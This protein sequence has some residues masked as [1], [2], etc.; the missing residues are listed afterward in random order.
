MHMN[1]GSQ[2]QLEP[3]RCTV[4]SGVPPG[5]PAGAGA[6]ATTAPTAAAPLSLASA[7][8]PKKGDGAGVEWR[9][10]GVGLWLVHSTPLLS[11]RWLAALCP[12]PCQRLPLHPITN[13][14]RAVAVRCEAAVHGCAALG[15]AALCGISHPVQ[16]ALQRCGMKGDG[17]CNWGGSTAAPTAQTAAASSDAH[18]GLRPPKVRPGLPHAYI[19]C[20]LQHFIAVYRPCFLSRCR[21]PRLPA[22]PTGSAG[23][24]PHLGCGANPCT[25]RDTAW[26]VCLQLSHPLSRV[27][28]GKPKP[29]AAAGCLG[30]SVCPTCSHT[31][32]APPRS[33]AARPGPGPSAPVAPPPPQVALHEVKFHPHRPT[34]AC[35]V[36]PGWC[37]DAALLRAPHCSERS[38]VLDS[39]TGSQLSLGRRASGGQ[40]GAT[41]AQAVEAPLAQRG[42]ADG[43]GA[44]GAG[45]RRSYSVTLLLPFHLP[46]PP[47]LAQAHRR[48]AAQNAAPAADATGQVARRR[49][50]RARGGGRQ[51]APPDH[52]LGH[53]DAHAGDCQRGCTKRDQAAHRGAQSGQQRRG[54][55]L[56]GAAGGR[57]AVGSQQSESDGAIAPCKPLQAIFNA[58]QRALSACRRP[59]C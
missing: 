12:H 53:C 6:A 1:C 10:L 25:T 55:H 4:K 23:G 48:A 54:A 38:F 27:F 21:L 8:A 49:A 7:F 9:W 29:I 40:A 28:R 47:Q 5:S 56:G 24:H 32:V 59:N 3:Q 42:A 52:L 35:A 15:V 39:K 37:T 57:A 58:P 41:L 51:P 34:H 14:C 46:P 26:F 30:C 50:H 44:H 31:G 2:A 11:L 13:S 43:A 19:F 16:V 33:L 17:S 22:P 18:V 20:I 36:G 45:H